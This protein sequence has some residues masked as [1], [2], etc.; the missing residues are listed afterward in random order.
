[1]GPSIPNLHSD[2]AISPPEAKQFLLAHTGELDLDATC[3]PLVG[4]PHSAC[5][6]PSGENDV[7]PNKAELLLPFNGKTRLDFKPFPVELEVK[8]VAPIEVPDRPIPLRTVARGGPKP[9]HTLTQEHGLDGQRQSVSASPQT[10]R[11]QVEAAT[12][13]VTQHHTSV[14]GFI[15]DFVKEHPA[16]MA[17]VAGSVAAYFGGGIKGAF[18]AGAAGYLGTKWFASWSERGEKASILDRVTEMQTTPNSGS[19]LAKQVPPAAQGS[20]LAKE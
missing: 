2:P 17:V 7:A 16:M 14:T 15:S 5:F 8:H 3:T 12:R 20:H 6:H 10:T 18:L 11:E 13:E 9:N 1:M 4:H 19:T